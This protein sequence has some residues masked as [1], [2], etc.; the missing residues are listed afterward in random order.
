MDY[1]SVTPLD[2]GRDTRKVYTRKA[3]WT[4]LVANARPHWEPNG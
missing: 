3:Y 4:N 1:S 2:T